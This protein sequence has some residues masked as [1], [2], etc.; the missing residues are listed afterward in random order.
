MVLPASGI[1]V[2]FSPLETGLRITALIVTILSGC[3]AIYFHIR[4]N[5]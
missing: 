5:R 3:V 4:K 2:S 1:A